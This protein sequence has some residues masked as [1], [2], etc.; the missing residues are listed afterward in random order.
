MHMITPHVHML[1][2]S[3]S[4]MKD[5]NGINRILYQNIAAQISQN[6]PRGSLLEAGNPY[7]E[8]L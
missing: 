4:V 1:P 3:N 8:L 2:C 6:L 5:N 7:R